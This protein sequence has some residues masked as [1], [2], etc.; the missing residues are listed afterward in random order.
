MLHLAIGCMASIH[1]DVESPDTLHDFQA[2]ERNTDAGPVACLN[3][4]CTCNAAFGR[5]GLTR[6]TVGCNSPYNIIRSPVATWLLT[7][8]CRC[9]G[10]S[11]RLCQVTCKPRSDCRTASQDTS[12]SAK[13]T[14]DNLLVTST[15]KH[16]EAS[17]LYA[18]VV[19]GQPRLVN[20]QQAHP[21]E[22][23]KDGYKYA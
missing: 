11:S 14:K 12:V 2:R 18:S 3:M 17:T 20:G 6:W 10:I 19:V 13:E 4:C 16:R 5:P 22:H 8:T 9:R 1:N 21:Q 15:K 23:P 7:M